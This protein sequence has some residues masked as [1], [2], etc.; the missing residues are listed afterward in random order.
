[1]SNILFYFLTLTTLV[2]LT[3]NGLV[4]LGRSLKIPALEFYGRSLASFVALFLSSVYATFAAAAFSAVGYGGMAQ[5]TAGR[6]FKWVMLLFT[7]IWFDVQD[8]E[9]YLGNTRPAVFVGNHQTELDVLMLGHIFPKW[10]SVTSKKSL[11]KIPFLGWFML[12]SKTVFIERKS[13]SQALQAFD[14]AAE[15]MRNE[16]QSVFIFPE[17][18]RSYYEKP[19]LLAFK[20]GA[21]HLAVQAQVPIVPIVSANYSNVLNVRSK[22]FQPGIIPTRVLKPIS[23][24]GKTKDDVDSLLEETRNVMMEALLELTEEARKQGVAKQEHEARSHSNGVAKSSGVD[25]ASK[26]MNAAA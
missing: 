6:F 17:G 23:T 21:F 2:T 15:Q 11:S 19:D 26:G 10:C 1:M 18:T 24:K 8:P 3:V 13:R 14:A 5:W 7:G 16:R 9:N 25:V 20:K 12:M 4:F 22:K